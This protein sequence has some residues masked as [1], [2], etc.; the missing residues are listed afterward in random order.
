MSRDAITR[1]EMGYENLPEY[2]G[3]LIGAP[4][5]PVASL[6]PVEAERYRK[7]QAQQ[8]CVRRTITV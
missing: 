5:R 6:A 2:L 4:L 7:E 3:Y 8:E 1:D